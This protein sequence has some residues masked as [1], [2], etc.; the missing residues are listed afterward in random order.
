MSTSGTGGIRTIEGL[1]QAKGLRFAIVA[2]RFNELP[3]SRLLA[4]ALDALTRHGAQ[5]GDITVVRVPGCWEI[6]GVARRLAVSRQHDAVIA[7][8]VLVRGETPHFDL[9]A[10]QVAR[11]LA[12]AAEETGT[13][14]ALGVVTADSAEQALDRA[15]GKHGN[16]G[17]EAAV[18]AIESAQVSQQL[19][20]L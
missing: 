9:I 16:R 6:P 14:I 18:A 13:P 20:S 2:S 19:G 7:L 10:A 5:P 12:S 3:S 1:L 11:G 15:G 8:G 17:W 4:G